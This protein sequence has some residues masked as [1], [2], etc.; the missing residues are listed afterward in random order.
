M[1]DAHF[2]D[3]KVAYECD[4]PSPSTISQELR[5]CTQHWANEK[6]KLVTV[7]DSLKQLSSDGLSEKL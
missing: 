5:L 6:D 3:L 1:S 7:R 4:I 2:K